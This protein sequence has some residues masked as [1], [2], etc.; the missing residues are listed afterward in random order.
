MLWAGIEITAA[1]RERGV[2]RGLGY[3][4]LVFAALILP[5]L[6]A[7]RAGRIEWRQDFIHSLQGD[8]NALGGT[9]LSGHVQCLYTIAECDTTLY[10]MQLVQSTGLF[11]DF[12][13]FGPEQNPIIEQNREKFWQE[14]QNNPP[15]VFVVGAELYPWGPENFGKLGLWPEFDQ[16][17]RDNY[18][19]YDQRWFR[20]GEPGPL[21]YRIYVAKEGSQVW[22]RNH[23]PKRPG[24]RMLVASSR[25]E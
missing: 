20:P 2:V 21:D 10:R 15:Q 12:L 22:A 1:L 5:F 4:G 6:Y 13:I 19:I 17:M 11:Y 23:V 9:S 8:L 24:E 3:A 18:R 14:L 16:F 25:A 7:A